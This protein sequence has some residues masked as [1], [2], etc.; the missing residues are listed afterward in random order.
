MGRAEAKIENYLRR[1]VRE[2]GGTIRKLRWLGRRGAADNLVS[3]GFPRVALAE[4]KREGE[5]IDPRSQQAR[6]LRRMRE[7]GWPVYVVS[8]KEQV[9]DMIA[10]VKG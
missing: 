5:D 4:C 8:S 6:D 7:D 1:R 2:M 9:E 10:E 3:F